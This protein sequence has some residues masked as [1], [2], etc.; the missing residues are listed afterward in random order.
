MRTLLLLLF[1][2]VTYTVGYA[3]MFDDGKTLYGNEWIVEGQRYLR[4][5]VAQ[6]GI[7][8]LTPDQLR[9]AGWPVDSINANQY[10]LWLRGEPQPLYA[11]TSAALETSDYLAFYGEKNQG[12]LD[13][14]LYEDP[15]AQQLNPRYSLITDTAVYF[16]TY[17]T[18][19]SISPHQYRSPTLEPSG[20]IAT[21][22]Y[23]W[24][25]REELFTNHFL[26]EFARI[27]GFSIYYSHYTIAEG[28]GSRSE[29]D[30]LSDGGTRQTVAT[31]QTPGAR[32]DGPPAQL[33]LRYA[34]GLG[35]HLQ[36][37]RADGSTIG[38][39]NDVGWS[40]RQVDSAIPSD[41]LADEALEVSIS[42][43]ATI[44]GQTQ[45]R[46]KASVA[47]IALRY[48]S[49]PDAEQQSSLR[50]ELAAHAQSVRLAIGNSNTTPSQVAL[51]DYQ[52]GERF[53]PIVENDSLVFYLP[54]V[55]EDRLCMLYDASRSAQTPASIAAARLLGAL[56]SE[57]DYLMLSSERLIQAG[58]TV[59]AYR[60]Y[61]ASLEGG[62]YRPAVVSVEDLYD[63]FG[64]GLQRHPMAIKN[65]LSWL[66]VQRPALKHLFIIGKGLEY[67]DIRRANQLANNA[68]V[69]FV[70]S[71]GFPASDAL[72]ASPVDELSLQLA[73]SRLPV[74]N[75]QELSIYLDK[76]Q[77]VEASNRTAPQTIEGRAWM[78]NLI[79]LGGGTGPEEQEQIRAHLE[80][81]ESIIE[82]NTFG[83]NVTG[84]YKT[85]VED[86]ET[87]RVDRIFNRIN[88]GLSIIT[89]FG[90]SSRGTFDFSIDNPE[91][92][93]NE[94]KYPLMLS[95]GCYSGNAFERTKSIGETFLFLKGGGAIAF[96][97]TR[98]I[99]FSGALAPFAS[100]FYELA[101]T[102]L[103]GAT[104]G[105]IT[106]ETI[107]RFANFNGIAFGTLAEQFGLIGDPAFRLHPQPGVDYTFDP[108]GVSFEPPVV[109]AQADSFDIDVGI[110]NLGRNESDSLRLRIEQQLPDD[111]KVLLAEEQLPSPSFA[112]TYRIRLPN[113]GNDAVGLN[114]ILAQIDPA[115]ELAEAPTGAE[116]NNLL[117]VNGQEGVPLFVVS[118]TALPRFPR[119]FSLVGNSQV[120][121]IAQTTDPLSNARL[122]QLELDTL[123]SF[124]SPL[125]STSVEQIGGVIR[126]RPTVAWQDS[127]TYYWRVSPDASETEN[128]DFVWSASN[129]TFLSNAP[130]GW[131]QNHWGQFQQNSFTD[132]RVNANQPFEFLSRPVN[133]ELFNGLWQGGQVRPGL[134]YDFSTSYAGSVNPWRWL[135]EGVA[136]VVSSPVTAGFWRSPQ[137]GTASDDPVYG[138]F[139]NKS[140]VFVWRTDSIG[141]RQ[142]L[143]TFLEEVVPEGFV[144]LLYTIQ[145]N[146]NEQRLYAEDWADD[147]ATAGRDLF[148]YLEEEGATQIRQLETKEV[149]YL[150]TYRKGFG[151]IRE[152]IADSLTQT[153]TFN[154]DLPENTSNGRMETVV[155]GPAVEWE[156]FRINGRT[157]SVDLNPIRLV[158][159]ASPNFLT[160]T[161]L[162]AERFST[163]RLDEFSSADYPY[164]AVVWEP[165]DEVERTP[166]NLEWIQ[167][168]YAGPADLTFDAAAHLE[169][170]PDSL[171]QGAVYPF[172][173]AVTN[174]QATPNDT[175]VVQ[176]RWLRGNELIETQ[177]RT[178]PP[179]QQA[180]TVHLQFA[181]DTRKAAGEQRVLLEINPARTV[182]EQT[183]TN[184]SLSFGFR[185]G[186][187]AIAPTMRVTF[188][189]RT[190]LDGDL[191]SS[192]PAIEVELRDENELLPL[193]DPESIALALVRPDGTQ[194]L[195]NGLDAEVEFIAGTTEDNTARLRLQPNLTQDGIYQL[196]VDSR[197]ISGNRSGE[198]AYE[199]S[200]E[201]ITE[202]LISNVVPYPNPFSDQTHFVYTL[203]GEEA[204]LD[205]VLTIMTVSGRVVRQLTAADLGPLRVG[206]NQTDFAWDGTDAFGDKLANGVYLYRM[207]VRD[208]EGTSLERYETSTDRF[209]RNELGKLVILR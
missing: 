87:S 137:E 202:S 149:P 57:V 186:Q 191:V 174:T 10:E 108:Q 66:K 147:R 53:V 102:T 123:P 74:E 183:Y 164:L 189:G 71:F 125:L 98:G 63:T 21:A 67:P 115:D 128:G 35:T 135:R 200:F 56:P 142:N 75:E 180:D 106:Q 91:N 42:G 188:D 54:P 155:V 178:L 39:L 139:T 185:T 58:T 124:E 100:E 13:A 163:L 152:E 4:I 204:P 134:I 121:L 93:R 170:G 92:Y 60:A 173:I 207:E 22:P 127:T 136:V 16:L 6:N 148:S 145:Y 62:S 150:F 171:Q 34:C 169:L 26:K 116:G 37:I 143:L 133:V 196:W 79:H 111:Q 110:V 141:Y 138:E 65:F 131:V 51:F 203:T 159:G 195:F 208:A 88:E 130:D 154:I 70:P 201:V 8:H 83:G 156:T 68:S 29:S 209:F 176:A 61:R 179:L 182:L 162:R 161:L 40:L 19:G 190:I 72:F 47:F 199:V 5:S 30:L 172:E 12:A 28:Y 50:F 33:S 84:F 85:G 1:F 118:N 114:T 45:L 107:N 24:K 3:Q 129:F 194:E 132:I 97:A 198:I 90:H 69:L 187:D 192:A 73:V 78:K 175:T 36:V 122:Y 43:E 109:F 158:G 18:A 80:R 112:E 82:T 104:I 113:Q 49:V 64:Y 27:S 9:I 86:F 126:W 167:L 94:G 177:E 206:R 46:D 146:E 168:E 14:H 81:M 151:V 96:G 120:E 157:D 119:P 31:F 32:A 193:D 23:I 77:S 25:E 89:F 103:Y 184:N 140:R 52:N 181:F 17:R 48:A 38:E 76:I 197:D 105:E 20:A 117:L 7:Y 165:Q 11:S 95:L 166:A 153:I 101:G 99:G 205:Y 59:E 160:D 15:T 2:C 41:Q 44:N 144:V 55:G